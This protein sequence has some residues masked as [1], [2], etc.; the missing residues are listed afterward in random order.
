MSQDVVRTIAPPR[1]DDRVD[2]RPIR[3]FRPDPGSYL[4]HLR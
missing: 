1:Q 3:R 2:S 4:R